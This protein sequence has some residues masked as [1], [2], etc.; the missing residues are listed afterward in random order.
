MLTVNNLVKR[1]GDHTA[2]DNLTFSVEGNGVFGF[3]GPN[4]AGKS[5]TM[6]IITGCL[7]ATSG[8]I[9]VNGFDAFRESK[10]ARRSIGYLPEIPPIYGELTPKEYLEFVASA[11]KIENCKKSAVIQEVMEKT[12]I[13]E[14]KDRLISNLSKGYKQRVGLAQA[15]IGNPQLLILDEPTVGLDPKQILDFRKLVLE[16]G[17]QCTVLL[18][19]H[20]LSEI[21]SV[22]KN[23]VIISNGRFVAQGSIEDLKANADHEARIIVSVPANKKDLAKSAIESIDNIKLC[24]IDSDAFSSKIF[25]TVSGADSQNVCESITHVLANKHCPVLGIEESKINLEQIFIEL[26]QSEKEGET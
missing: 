8:E 23:V 4:G 16:L 18:S 24:N 22:C 1:Y 19:S 14:M 11:K 9:I 17:E 25:F 3:L 5:T 20:I 15:I 10:L 21:S 6:N 7:S 13:V 12:S 2:V 26:T